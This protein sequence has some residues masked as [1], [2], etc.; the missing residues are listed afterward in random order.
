MNLDNLGKVQDGKDEMSDC[1]CHQHAPVAW[2]FMIISSIVSTQIDAIA[3]SA[4]TSNQT[5][6]Q[7]NVSSNQLQDACDV[8]WSHPTV[9]HQ[10][11][12]LRF[13]LLLF[14]RRRAAAWNVDLNVPI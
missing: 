12:H 11:K 10:N 5:D 14:W 7:N 6:P 1:E 4:A 13:R 3:T 8:R 9:F 2:V